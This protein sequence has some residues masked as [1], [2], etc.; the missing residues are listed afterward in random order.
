MGVLR[1][2]STAIL[3]WFGREII[4][5]AIGYNTGRSFVGIGAY[6]L[7]IR[8]R[9]L[10]H[11]SISL[12]MTQPAWHEL[13]ELAEVYG[14]NPLGSAW[15]GLGSLLDLDADIYRAGSHSPVG[16]LAWD[17]E[18]ALEACS[19]ITREDALSMR[20]ALDQAFLEVEPQRV[21]AS[22]YLF[23]PDDAHLRWR[24]GVGV[25]AALA[26]FCRLGSFTVEAIS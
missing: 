1:I 16:R 7:I 20:E 11:P 18:L 12:S 17:A 25:L 6:R 19:V 15:P 13:L 3:N 21:P 23:E 2:A 22:Y 8:L 10:Q 4:L 14:W 26:D 5:A 24:P 9:S